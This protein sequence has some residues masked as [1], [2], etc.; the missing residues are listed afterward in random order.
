M[1]KVIR[2]TLPKE[3]SIGVLILIFSLAFILSG[4]L[5]DSHA[6]VD[7]PNI[8]LGMFLVSSAA[9]IMVIILWEEIL[10]PIHVKPKDG[11]IVFR[12]HRNKLKAQALIYLIIPA[13]VVFLYLNYKVNL[14]YFISWAVVNLAAPVIGKLI[15]GIH[16][17]ND[18]LRLNAN[19]IEY[20]NN[21]K[22]GTIQIKDIKNIEL[23]KA[24]GFLSKLELDL[25]HQGR[26]TIDLDE[27]EL[28]EFYE[29]IE[30]YITTQYDSLI[31]Q[32]KA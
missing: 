3:I 23:V 19:L 24:D 2:P 4:Q 15:S 30:Q 8:Y 5:F 1:K 22:E 29:T 27:M 11:E 26:Q 7:S 12:N 17:Y 6:N 32:N 14:F 21:E 18:F 25:V 10:F 9:I 28:D 20:K 13:I 31:K 16:N